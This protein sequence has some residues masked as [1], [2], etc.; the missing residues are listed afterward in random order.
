MGIIKDLHW[1]TVKI[2]A[3]W[4]CSFKTHRMG[5]QNQPWTFSP[6][7]VQPIHLESRLKQAN[8]LSDY[9]ENVRRV[10]F[11]LQF[12]HRMSHFSGPGLI[13]EVLNPTPH[14]AWN[15]SFLSCSPLRVYYNGSTKDKNKRESKVFLTF[16][17]QFILRFSK[18]FCSAF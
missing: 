4:K 9:L 15:L 12:N 3:L 16:F 7:P 8:F 17:P 5:E 6:L 11:F 2:L 18:M 1:M 14:L 13:L 10:Y